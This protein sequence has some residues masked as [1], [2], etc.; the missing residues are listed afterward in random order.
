MLI[1]F[2]ASRRFHR[3]LRAAARER[4]VSIS[5]LIRQALAHHLDQ[6]DLAETPTPWRLPD[7]DQLHAHS[8]PATTARPGVPD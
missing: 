1:T 4:N 2:K 3:A 7:D 5:Y 8:P 6:P